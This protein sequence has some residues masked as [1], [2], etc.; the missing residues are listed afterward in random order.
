MSPEEVINAT[1]ING[2]YAMGVEKELGSI[3]VGK[4]ANFFITKPITS[5]PYL[6]YSFGENIIKKVFIN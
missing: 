5:Y 4:K 3:C 1:T 2:A 6:H